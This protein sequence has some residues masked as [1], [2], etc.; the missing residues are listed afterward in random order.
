METTAITRLSR[1]YTVQSCGGFSYI[2]EYGGSEATKIMVR[3]AETE[4]GKFTLRP[5]NFKT[6]N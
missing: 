2:E 6:A 5:E 1:T 3:F 4:T